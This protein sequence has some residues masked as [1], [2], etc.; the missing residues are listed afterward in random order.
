M[1]RICSSGPATA[2][3]RQPRARKRCAHCVAPP[4]KQSESD[5]S[6]MT[7]GRF[8]YARHPEDPRFPFWILPTL[9]CETYL[10]GMDGSLLPDIGGGTL[11]SPVDLRPSRVLAAIRSANARLATRTAASKPGWRDVIAMLS[12]PSLSLVIRPTLRV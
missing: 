4:A 5:G 7:N 3:G 8:H 11:A 12:L 10:L 6:R 9:P 2:S 1:S